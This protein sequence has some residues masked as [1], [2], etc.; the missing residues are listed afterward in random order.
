[1][2]ASSEH[3]FEGQVSRELIRVTSRAYPGKSKLRDQQPQ[4]RKID[5]AS[6]WNSIER[7]T[8]LH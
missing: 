6:T 7:D 2:A 5:L 3:E 4:N 8:E 1:M